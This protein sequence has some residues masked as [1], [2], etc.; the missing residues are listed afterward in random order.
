[1]MNY[2]LKQQQQQSV[3]EGTTSPIAATGHDQIECM[4]PR[5]ISA[6]TDPISQQDILVRTHRRDDSRRSHSTSSG[7]S[8]VQ[9][10][11]LDESVL[12]SSH[13]NRHSSSGRDYYC[14]SPVRSSNG[15]RV[16]ASFAD[17]DDASTLPTFVSVGESLPSYLQSKH[18]TVSKEQDDYTTADDDE[19]QQ[20]PPLLT[21]VSLEAQNSQDNDRRKK[22]YYKTRLR[23]L[24]DRL[25]TSSAVQRAKDMTKGVIS[26]ATP[27][28][29]KEDRQNIRIETLNNKNGIISAT[30]NNIKLNIDGVGSPQQESSISDSA[31]RI[32]KGMRKALSACVCDNI[33]L[34]DAVINHEGL[35]IEFKSKSKSRNKFVV[36]DTCQCAGD[37]LHANDS[38]CSYSTTSS[39]NGTDISSLTGLTPHRYQTRYWMDYTPKEEMK[40]V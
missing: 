3:K 8:A 15:G 37:I 23:S 13:N 28:T 33:C 10:A 30:D 1:M 24:T 9:Q 25:T 22:L 38:A 6:S 11:F 2:L 39:S 18:R 32:I 21:L 12:S 31:G 7:L 16:P 36:M 29:E 17:T 26:V 20:R 27:S 4:V 14:S 35:V 19:Q 34:D 40:W 5:E